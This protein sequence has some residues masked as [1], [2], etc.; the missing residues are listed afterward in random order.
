[1][2]AM[3]ENEFY[4]RSDMEFLAKTALKQHKKANGLNACKKAVGYVQK[5][6]GHIVHTHAEPGMAMWHYLGSST[7]AK[8]WEVD[9]E[10]TAPG[11][12]R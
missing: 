9:K 10:S 1:M 4:K 12:N 3:K 2:K 7:A 5:H 8:P 6:L 11:P